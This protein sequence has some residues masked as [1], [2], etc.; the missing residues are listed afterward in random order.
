MHYAPTPHVF[1]VAPVLEKY[2]V[3]HLLCVASIQGVV[4]YG[5]SQ[6]TAFSP[7][8]SNT[9]P[10]TDFHGNGQNLQAKKKKNLQEKTKLPNRQ[11]CISKSAGLV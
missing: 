3:L 2:M 1:Q 7:A 9:K 10:L 11:R 6:Y 4:G 5:F 8:L